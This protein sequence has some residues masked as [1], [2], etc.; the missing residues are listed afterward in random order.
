MSLFCVATVRSFVAANCKA[1][2]FY[3]FN[4]AFPK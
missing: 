2:K 1:L 4:I 3:S